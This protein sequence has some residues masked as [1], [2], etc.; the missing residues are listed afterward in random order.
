MTRK[1]II[2]RHIII[3]SATHFRT[4]IEENLKANM[5]AFVHVSVTQQI[6][7]HKH[8]RLHYSLKN[9]VYFIGI[10][11]LTFKHNILCSPEIE[12]VGLFL[13]Q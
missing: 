8:N 9:G 12:W 10:D 11:V 3:R 5:A 2:I 13:W 7:V 6:L 4:P 1:Y